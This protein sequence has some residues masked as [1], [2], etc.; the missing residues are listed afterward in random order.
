[1]ALQAI[2]PS[3]SSLGQ[4]A[5]V[6]REAGYAVLASDD[7]LPLIQGSSE[8]LLEFQSS[9]QALPPDNYLLDDGR[10][11]RRRHSCFIRE[12]SHFWQAA[13]RAHWQP[14]EFNA[15]HGGIRRAYEPV[16]REIVQSRAWL[17]ILM[18]VADICSTVKPAPR[19]CIEAHQFRI[20][21]PDGVGLPT[22]EGTHRDGVDFVAILLVDRRDVEGGESRVFEANGHQGARF[23]L[24]EPW[25][26]LIIDDTRMIHETTPIRSSDGMGYRDTLVL[27]FRSRQFL[28]D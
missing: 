11:R 21:T 27:T 10:Y 3:V 19:W 8:E 14:M 9:W 2:L 4:T 18:N 16:R 5:A 23:T 26:L 22:P 25:T 6:L 12:G 17:K 15:L 1:M 7:I 28:G 24:L 13:H 20:T